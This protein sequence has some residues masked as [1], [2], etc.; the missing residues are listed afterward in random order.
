[1]ITDNQERFVETSLAIFLE[2]ATSSIRNAGVRRVQN[3]I[4]HQ[5]LSVSCNV[6]CTLI[7]QDICNF[8]WTNESGGFC[9][10]CNCNGLL[11]NF[12]RLQWYCT[13]YDFSRI[14]IFAQH[15]NGSWMLLSH[16]KFAPFIRPSV[17]L[18]KEIKRFRRTVTYE[19]NV[20]L[21]DW[22]M[23]SSC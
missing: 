16:Y 20:T 18:T 1:M 2:N 6:L 13:F 21:K 22:S 14:N 15:N 10:K 8:S 19:Q 17:I 4:Q 3:Q 5:P 9:S 12:E 7:I 23:R 11:K